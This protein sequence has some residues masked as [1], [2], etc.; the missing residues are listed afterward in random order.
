VVSGEALAIVGDGGYDL[1]ARAMQIRDGLMARD[2]FEPVDML[3]VHLDD[4]ALFLERWRSLL[5]ELLDEEALR[6]RAERAEFRRLVADWTPRASVDSVGYR[7]VRGFRR[8]VR[9]TVFDMLTLPIVERFGP[10]AP[11]RMSRQF[12]G[13]LWTAVTE[14]PAHLLAGNSATWRELL[15]GAV[16]RNLDYYASNYA[17]GL[18]QRTWGEFNTGEFGH[19][20]SAALP[21]L[22]TV[23]DLPS[24]PLPGD[25]NMPRVQGPTFGA[26]E[27]FAVAP[28]DEASSYL[29]MPGGQS[30]HPL[31]PYRLAGHEAWASGSA[32]PFL[33]GPP[34]HSLTLEPAAP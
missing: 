2:R 26:S 22:A 29:H 12:E 18:S 14:R 24:Q 33:P 8:E 21:V 5:L 15:L 9:D 28:G 31:S 32:S 25:N 11:R 23:F 7:L 3:D 1:G 13:A 20:L 16:D 34:V 19:P 17:D 27:R 4:R 6:G 30:G 10:D